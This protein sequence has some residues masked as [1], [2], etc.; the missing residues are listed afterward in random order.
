MNY[1]LK[2]TADSKKIEKRGGGAKA[3]KNTGIKQSTSGR[4]ILI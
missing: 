2:M 1:G 3:Q 4:K